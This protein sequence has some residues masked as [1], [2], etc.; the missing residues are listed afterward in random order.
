MNSI[1]YG[2]DRYKLKGKKKYLGKIKGKYHILEI[3]SY[4]GTLQEVYDILYSTS[5]IFR[6]ILIENY[7]FIK[8]PLSGYFDLN[9]FPIHEYDFNHH[10]R[11]MILP[12]PATNTTNFSSLT[13]FT[14][15][16]QE[17]LE[18]ACKFVEI[19]GRFSN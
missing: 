16:C 18:L 3:L 11:L 4:T 14:I 5:T 19:H 1:K 8:S 10:I 2:P 13:N 6:D 12:T 15:I 7:G 17:D 9:N